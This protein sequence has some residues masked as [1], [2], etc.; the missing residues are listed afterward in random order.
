MWSD[1]VRNTVPHGL[2]HP[3]PSW[4]PAAKVYKLQLLKV[5]I[6]GKILL[7]KAPENG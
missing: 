7:A 4:S 6:E 3:T 5:A 2:W 1:I